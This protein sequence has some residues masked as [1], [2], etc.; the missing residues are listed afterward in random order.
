MKA[1]GGWDSSLTPHKICDAFT[2][3]H[4][5]PEKE[6]FEKVYTK[7]AKKRFEKALPGF[8]FKT[9]DIVGMQMLCGYQLVI[10]GNSPICELFTKDD[11]LGFEYAQDLHYNKMVGYESKVGPYLGF[12]W[13]NTGKQASSS[14]R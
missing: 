3:E 9:K 14:L 5:K 8:K 10:E 13:L 12:P 6:F 4:G 11:W 1:P 7:S 2:K